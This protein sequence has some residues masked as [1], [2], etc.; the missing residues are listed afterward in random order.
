MVSMAFGGAPFGDELGDLHDA[1]KALVSKFEH[2]L[3]VSWT[4]DL[5]VSNLFS[6]FE[7]RLVLIRIDYR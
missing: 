6:Y 7:R 1:K 5:K 4:L 2:S 3:P